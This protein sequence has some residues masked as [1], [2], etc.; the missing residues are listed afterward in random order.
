MGWD[1]YHIH[2]FRVGK[3]VWGPPLEF[4]DY[5]DDA[6]KPK[7]HRRTTLAKVASRKHSLLKYQYDGG[8]CWMHNVFV[9][10]V[11]APEPEQCYPVCLEGKRACP[12]EDCGGIPGFYD[13]LEALA[14]KKHP[15]HEHLTEWVGGEFDPKALNL[16]EVNRELKSLQ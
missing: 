5:F 2:E 7:D 14:D 10:D 15:D 3:E 8:D 16:D 12:P 4:D 6:S 11:L 1:G 13:L 9:E